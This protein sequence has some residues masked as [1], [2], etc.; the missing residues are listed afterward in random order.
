MFTGRRVCG[1]GST[2]WYACVE[3]E[4]SLCKRVLLALDGHVLL[5]FTRGFEGN[6]YLIK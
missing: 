4:Q 3:G 1:T 6:S 2:N 5:L